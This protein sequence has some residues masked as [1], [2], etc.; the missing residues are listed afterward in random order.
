MEGMYERYDGKGFP[1]GSSAKEIPL[2]ARLLAIADTYANLVDLFKHTVTGEDGLARSA[3]ARRHAPHGR[4]AAL[5]LAR[6]LA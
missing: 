1:D 5:T 2:G 4:G 6:Q 3:V